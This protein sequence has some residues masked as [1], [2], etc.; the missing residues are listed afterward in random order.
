MEGGDQ[1][2]KVRMRLLEK[3]QIIGCVSFVFLFLS[4]VV[5]LNTEPFLVACNYFSS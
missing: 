2:A 4:A 5:S 1:E 3:K